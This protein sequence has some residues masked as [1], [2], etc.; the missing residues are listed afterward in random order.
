M[1]AR[2]DLGGEATGEL[3]FGEEVIE[4]DTTRGEEARSSGDDT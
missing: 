1:E 2:R 3:A 4:G